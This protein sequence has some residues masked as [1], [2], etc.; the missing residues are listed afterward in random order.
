MTISE[1]RKE[2]R[3]DK[4]CELVCVYVYVCVCVFVCECVC[5]SLWVV[6]VGY[7]PWCPMGRIRVSREDER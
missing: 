4:M 5:E 2:G 6:T 7:L 1:G 3:N